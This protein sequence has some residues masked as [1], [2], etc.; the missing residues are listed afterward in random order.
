M[1]LSVSLNPSWSITGTFLKG[2]ILAK[3][4]VKC[5]PMKIKSIDYNS[6]KKCCY[7]FAML[8]V[9]LQMGWHLHLLSRILKEPLKAVTWHHSTIL[10]P[11]FQEIILF[12]QYKLNELIVMMLWTIYVSPSSVESYQVGWR[13][14]NILELFNFVYCSKVSFIDSTSFASY[15]K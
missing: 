4:F 11:F 12:L 2:F 3:S 15:R 7:L 8:R 9:L 10:R 6:L 13:S 5:S 1:Y 14:Y